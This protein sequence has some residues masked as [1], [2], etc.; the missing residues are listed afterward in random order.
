MATKSAQAYRKILKL[1][2]RKHFQGDI[3]FSVRELARILGMS[4]VPVSEAIRRLQQQGFIICQP[5]RRLRVR[6]LSDREFT[7]VMIVREGLECQ[8]VGILTRFP[9]PKVLDDLKNRAEKI[10]DAVRRGRI[11]ALPFLE[12]EFHVALARA[13][14][15]GILAEKIEE[16]ALM[17][18]LCAEPIDIDRTIELDR[19]PKIVRALASGNPQLAEQTMREHLGGI[20]RYAENK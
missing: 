19:H 17:T 6:I 8:A 9:D 16:L 14:G 2:L 20:A 7:D 11:D 18:L 13:T 15:C 5:R 1:L 3:R 4:V 10:D 12:F